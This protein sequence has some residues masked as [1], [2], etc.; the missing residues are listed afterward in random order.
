MLRNGLLLFLPVSIPWAWVLNPGPAAFSTPEDVSALSANAVTLSR[1]G[2]FRQAFPIFTKLAA[3]EPSD[4]APNLHVL[5][6]AIHLTE[7]MW[8][9]KR[10]LLRSN[11]RNGDLE[12]IGLAFHE[13]RAFGFPR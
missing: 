2:S 1:K 6:G 11:G 5:G 4:P 3:P 8:N 7:S 13:G 10:Y 9:G 12:Q